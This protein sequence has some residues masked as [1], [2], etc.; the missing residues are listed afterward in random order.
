MPTIKEYKQFFLRNIQVNS[1]ANPDQESGYPLQYTIIGKGNVYNRL[2]QG[3]YPSEGVF[4]KLLES[5]PFLLNTEDT[6]TQNSQGLVRIATDGEAIGRVDNS[7]GTFT[8]VIAPHQLPDV[9]LTTDGADT[10]V[11][12]PVEEGGLKLSKITRLVSGLSW[13]NFKVEVNRDNSIVINNTSKKIELDGDVLNPGNKYYYGTNASG[14]KGWYSINTIKFPYKVVDSYAD[15]T[16]LT[17]TNGSSVITDMYTY[18]LPAN[19]IVSP[20]D[21]LH[22]NSM[23]D[24][25]IG[26]VFYSLY[27][28]ALLIKT[29]NFNDSNAAKCD[30]TYE[31]TNL[32]IVSGTNKALI[33]INLRVYN[34]T[35]GTEQSFIDSAIVNFDPT[36]NNTIIQRVTN[37]SANTIINIKKVLTTL[38][39]V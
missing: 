21:S 7:V 14:V 34:L 19:T 3:N 2:L 25:T 13:R 11:G 24:Y 5:I 15:Y 23:L 6:A 10:V 31:L 18:T 20:K 12:T 33:T 38:K 27:I 1:G 9:V 26:G 22:I 8:N 17:N 35:S 39:L 29:W 37:G 32:G 16:G 4:R 36:I 28:G 30:F